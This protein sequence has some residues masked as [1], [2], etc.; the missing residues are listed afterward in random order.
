MELIVIC[1]CKDKRSFQAAQ[2]NSEAV[3]TEQSPCA[4]QWSNGRST[5]STWLGNTK[6]CLISYMWNGFIWDQKWTSVWLCEIDLQCKSFG[7][8]PSSNPN[9]AVMT[10]TCRF[11][12]LCLKSETASNCKHTWLNPEC[13]TVVLT[14]RVVLWSAGT[15][16]L[17]H[18]VH[19]ASHC[20]QCPVAGVLTSGKC[21]YCS[22]VPLWRA[23]QWSMT[24]SRPPQ[25]YRTHDGEAIITGRTRQE[26]NP[27]TFFIKERV[28]SRPSFEF[29][30]AL[31]CTQGE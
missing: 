15:I 11:S 18:A 8:S 12:F 19:N 13:L 4:Q 7:Q 14:P 2:R 24:L 29:H 25:H 21:F 10:G 16:C 28:D 5:H 1:M 31:R 17:R 3:N 26:I 23:G 22:V 9:W 30:T 27:E 20:P 6:E